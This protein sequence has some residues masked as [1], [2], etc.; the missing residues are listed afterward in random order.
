MSQSPRDRAAQQP[1]PTTLPPR[2]MLLERDEYVPK[3]AAEEF[4]VPLLNRWVKE[5]IV[6]WGDRVSSPLR[7]L[8]VGCGRQPFRKVIEQVGLRYIGLDAVQNPEGTVDLVCEID[9][10]LPAELEARHFELII[11][12]EVLEHVADWSSAWENLARLLAPGGHLIV[13]CPHFYMLHEEPYD[14]WRPTLN[15]LRW[16]AEANGLSAVELSPGGDRWA[17]LG[18]FLGA[19]S[20]RP[21]RAGITARAAAGMVG[22]VRRMV[23]SVLR[24]GWI[25]RFVALDGRM[26]LSSLAVFTKPA[27][28]SG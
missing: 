5:A 3:G 10:P 22:R 16:F 24:H 20:E 11:C 25:Q 4:I 28:T 19:V 23:F 27:T 12:T 13:T 8:D 15:A 17:I 1:G 2:P 6:R 26:Y 14:F 21:A 7:C 9:R 18:T